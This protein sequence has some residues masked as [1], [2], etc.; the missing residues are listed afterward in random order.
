MQQLIL[1]IEHPN[2]DIAMLAIKVLT[3]L[4]EDRDLD[5]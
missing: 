5:P 3:E 4:G 1:L 2:P